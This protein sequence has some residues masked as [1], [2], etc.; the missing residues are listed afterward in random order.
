MHHSKAALKHNASLFSTCLTTQIALGTNPFVTP[1]GAEKHLDV[2]YNTV[3][4]HPEIACSKSARISSSASTP[5]DSRIRLSDTPARR[6][7]SGAIPRWLDMAGRVAR[8]SMPPK[9]TA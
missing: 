7:A 5:T 4:R 3:M 6:R 8:L 1:R 2:A 9:L